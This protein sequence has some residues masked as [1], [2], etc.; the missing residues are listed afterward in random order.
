VSFELPPD[1]GGAVSGSF[2]HG[3]VVIPAVHIS[4]AADVVVIEDD[5][6]VRRALAR[7]LRAEGFVVETWSSAEDYLTLDESATACLVLDVR[8][9]GMSGFGLQDHLLAAGRVV[10]IIFI[11][12]HADAL[13]FERL[14]LPGTVALIAKPLDTDRLLALLAEVRSSQSGR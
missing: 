6:S 14:R 9:G 1:R 7:L 11:S 3:P 13:G 8:L 12:G 10:P 2:P 4:P 5:D